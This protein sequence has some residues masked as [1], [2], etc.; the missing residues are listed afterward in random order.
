[1]P[2]RDSQFSNASDP[3]FS[4]VK[5]LGFQYLV[6]I[7]IR[8]DANLSDVGLASLTLKNTHQ[9]NIGMLPTLLSRS[10][11][12]HGAGRT[13]AR[14][15]SGSGLYLDG[16]RGGRHTREVMSS[17]P[18]VYDIDVAEPDPL[19]VRC[20]WHTI[21]SSAAPSGL[22]FIE[23]DEP[24]G[25]IVPSGVPL[26]DSM[27]LQRRVQIQRVSLVRR[28]HDVEIHSGMQQCCNQ[29]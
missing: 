17:L 27:D 15:H 4:D 12:D 7:R 6:R 29:L 19:K 18:H 16:E 2:D 1:M 3:R 13:D 23:I 14:L 9:L 22:A 11:Y 25:G 8:A 5:F 20:L 28:W 10:E 26:P 21:T 24:D